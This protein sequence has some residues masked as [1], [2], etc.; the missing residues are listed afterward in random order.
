MGC[1]ICQLNSHGVN[2]SDQ[3]PRTRNCTPK[4]SKTSR[5]HK[6]RDGLRGEAQ[7]TRAAEMQT[8]NWSYN[9]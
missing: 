7:Q 6:M 1:G 9:W 2:E 8:E 4:R 3:V 5:L